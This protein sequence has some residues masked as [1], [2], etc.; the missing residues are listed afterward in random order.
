VDRT[1]L[2]GLTA[3]LRC[4]WFMEGEMK[5]Y[6][7]AM[8]CIC[9]FPAAAFP[10]GHRVPPIGELIPESAT[11][12]AI[13]NVNIMKKDQNSIDI[14]NGCSI[15]AYFN[16]PFNTPHNALRPTMLSLLKKLKNDNPDC[17]RIVIYL[18]PCSK[19]EKTTLSLGTCSYDWGCITLKY[20][21]VTTDKT[22]KPLDNREFD[23]AARVWKAIFKPP[24]RDMEENDKMYGL[25]VKKLKIKMTGLSLEKLLGRLT[26]FYSPFGP[27]ETIGS[28]AK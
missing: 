12:G 10:A 23:I 28:C 15:Y 6:L 4:R 9:C 22:G 20:P 26:Y 25:V 1:T 3:S 21:P 18:Y 14:D 24:F 13:T 27:S 11:C 2:A 8:L 16:A 5:K 19:K 7:I 17:E